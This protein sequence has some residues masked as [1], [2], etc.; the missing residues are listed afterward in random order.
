MH[1]D[2]LQRGDE[3]RFV[4]GQGTTVY[5]VIGGRTINRGANDV[6]QPTSDNRL[7]L[8][9]SEPELAGERYAVIARM[10]GKAL[11]SPEGWP[12]E[13]RQSELGLNTDGGNVVALVLWLQLLL[14]A[15]LATVWLLRKYS[16][17]SVYVIMTPVLLLLALLVFDSATALLPSTL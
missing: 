13:L 6:I 12:T 15:S 3:I 16:Q 9:T 4:T 14:I 10:E 8:I 7:T 5:R 1:L 2:R 11:A 17:P